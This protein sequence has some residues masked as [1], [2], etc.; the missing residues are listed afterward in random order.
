MSAGRDDPE[1][2]PALAALTAL[3]RDAVEPHTQAELDEGSRAL[4]RRVAAGRE[5]RRALA[6]LTLLGAAAACVALALQ[7]AAARRR[8][9]PVPEPA[10]AVARIEG[11]ALV[12][13]GYLSKTGA[14]GVTVIFSEGS[15]FELMPGARGRLRSVDAS[16]ARLAL[17]NGTAALH[18][19]PSRE[20]RWWVEAGPFLVTVKG[21]VFTVSWDPAGERFELVLQQ[22]HVVVSGPGG[23]IALRAGQHLVV[24]LPEAETVITGEPPASAPD[25]GRPSAPSAVTVTLG[26]PKGPTVARRAASGAAASPP[27]GKV[28]GGRRWAAELARGSWD[29]ILAD[30]DHDGVDVTLANASSDDLFA[31]ADAARYRRRTDL[32]RAALVAERRRFPRAPRSLDAIFLLGRVEELRPQGAAQAISWYDAYLAEAPTG[33]YAAEALGRKMI[34]TDEREGRTAARPIADEY[35]RRFPAGSYAGSARALQRAP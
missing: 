3:G 23:E 4:R 2:S 28:G 26:P 10:V 33:A 27:G 30:V 29:G 31:L 34:L 35:L 19:T 21:T 14:A 12:E 18:V 16:G 17:E 22:G 32:A 13:G 7:V 20:R 25:A 5:R 11:G 1:D 8:H 15:R 9:A 6:A 24:S